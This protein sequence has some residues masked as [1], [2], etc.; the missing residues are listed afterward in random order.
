MAELAN[1]L[2]PGVP[3]SNI[4]I[5]PGEKLHEVMITQDD[6]RNTVEFHDRFIIQPAFGFWGSDRSYSN[7]AKPV[8]DGFTYSSDT[9][10]E[11]LTPETLKQMC[12]I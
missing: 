2:A 12:G 8:A 4:G 3:H 7:R 1:V 11:W 5:R 9:N 6:A 10:S